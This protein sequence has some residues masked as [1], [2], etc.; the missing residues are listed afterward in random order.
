MKQEF[1]REYKIFSRFVEDCHHSS[2]GNCVQKSMNMSKDQQKVIKSIALYTLASII[3]FPVFHWRKG[4]FNWNDTLLYWALITAVNIIIS[5]LF[6]LG[7][8]RPKN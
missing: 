6:V 8:K 4:D 5:L 2:L 1:V 3:V 7:M